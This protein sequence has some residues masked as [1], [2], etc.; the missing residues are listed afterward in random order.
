MAP[1]QLAGREVSVRSD[2]YSLGLVLYELFT[3]QPAFRAET[4]AELRRLQS[5]STPT[6]PS[7]LLEGL[8][9]RVERVIL[10]CLE[11]DPARRPPSA[12][13]VAAGLPGGD[14]LAAALAAGETPSPQMVAEAEDG[15]NLAPALSWAAAALLVASLAGVL[16]LSP[17]TALIGMV[18]LDKPPEALQERAREI[19][20]KAGH[21]EKPADSVYTFD[22][23]VAYLE[24][25]RARP[26]RHRWDA[27]RTVPSRRRH[28]VYRQ[29]P[30]EL[31]PL[32]G[33]AIGNR[34]VDPPMVRPG[35]AQV[36]L[37]PEGR[38]VSLLVVPGERTATSAE[39]DW[40][41]LLTATGVD[42]GTLAPTAPEW[43]PPVFADRRAA[44]TA[45][46]AGRPGVPLRI[47]AAAASGKPVWLRIV[48][49]WTRP[50]EEPEPAKDFGSRV[51]AVMNAVLFCLVTVL[52]AFVALRNVRRG[53]GDRR[54]ALRLALYLGAVRMLWFPGRPPR[55]LARGD[56][57]VH[58]PLRLR[59]D[60]GGAGLRLLSGARALR[61][62][63]VAPDAGV[64]GAGAGGAVPR[65]P[66]GA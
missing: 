38:L 54:G 9:P 58:R 21:A 61:A 36:A 26:D 17:R 41:P 18:P 49:P 65:S 10:R 22:A 63:A 8:D 1:E 59:D 47:E 19:L 44:W 46:W 15:T 3:G 28:F 52:A 5:E 4:V 43:A 12:L 42:A 51:A 33:A 45:Q 57:P 66:G 20:A 25:A 31:V 39:P 50:A 23:D 62:E 48:T 55:G 32:N 60:A 35:M 40:S 29:G 30:G 14:P 6:S 11:P 34:A 27:L 56:G 13:A 64:L 53:R 7:S 37:D 16:F 2:L 24:S